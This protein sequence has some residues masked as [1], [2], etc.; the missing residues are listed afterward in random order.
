VR[1]APSINGAVRCFFHLPI[2]GAS[3]GVCV[4]LGKREGR[5]ERGRAHQGGPRSATKRLSA[6][7]SLKWAPRRES[8]DVRATQFTPPITI[9]S[10]AKH[11]LFSLHAIGENLVVNLPVSR[12]AATHAD[13]NER[14]GG[15]GLGDHRLSVDARGHRAPV[16]AELVEG[17]GASPSRA[18]RA[19]GPVRILP[20]PYT[21]GDSAGPNRNQSIRVHRVSGRYQ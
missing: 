19:Q 1:T 13:H 6:T 16:Q 10:T 7:V 18:G 17:G 8:S 5:S 3:I 12:S 15:C 14:V 4:S 21:C 11:H 9:A 20:T 2:C